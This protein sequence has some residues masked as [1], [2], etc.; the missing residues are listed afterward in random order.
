MEQIT[1]RKLDHTGHQITAYPGEV[2]RRTDDVLVLR[3][4][5]TRPP[6][7]LGFVTF[8]TG[9]RWT[10]W[11]FVR[12]WFNV[13]EIRARDGRLQGWYCNITRPPYVTADEVAAE[14]L[15]LDLWVAADGT[16]RVL[17]EDE[18]AALPI[19]PQEREAALDALYE[20]QTMVS[21]ESPPFDRMRDDA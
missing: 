19:S 6:L 11:F 15:A 1:V 18:F 10:E 13:F 3:T 17:D 5:W 4:T 20:L 14:D 7:D 9:S 2:L 12:R 8:E 16:A 21:R